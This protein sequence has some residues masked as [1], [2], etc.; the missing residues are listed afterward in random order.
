MEGG[1]F[2]VC[3]FFRLQWVLGSLTGEWHLR[4]RPCTVSKPLQVILCKL[5]YCYRF[6][7]LQGLFYIVN[8]FFIVC[9]FFFFCLENNDHFRVAHLKIKHDLRMIFLIESFYKI[10]LKNKYLCSSFCPSMCIFFY[11]IQTFVSSKCFWSLC[12]L[13]S[14]KLIIFIYFMQNPTVRNNLMKK[15]FINKNRK[16]F[17]CFLNS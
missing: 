3:L 9:G 2:C 13:L 10:H 11:S 1:C 16:M 8:L 15:Q 14:V 4:C 7:T 5:H 12:I 6:S 17:S